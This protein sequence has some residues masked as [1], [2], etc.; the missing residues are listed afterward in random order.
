M[1]TQNENSLE[2]SK[3]QETPELNIEVKRWPLAPLF[4]LFEIP[5]VALILHGMAYAFNLPG[6]EVT[7]N[8]Y[9]GQQPIALEFF[10]FAATGGLLFPLAMG[11]WLSLLIAT[12]PKLTGLRIGVVLGLSYLAASVAWW[13]LM[14]IGVMTRFV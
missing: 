6:S 4:V 9:G 1:E 10:R 5:A 7:V 3:Q 8:S 14:G 11:Y 2:M 13:V 12:E